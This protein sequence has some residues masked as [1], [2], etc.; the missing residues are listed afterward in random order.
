[1]REYTIRNKSTNPIV[2]LTS[3]V[4]QKAMLARAESVSLALAKLASDYKQLTGKRITLDH[5]QDMALREKAGANAGG[6]W[7]SRYSE[8]PYPLSHIQ[9]T[10]TDGFLNR[11][12]AGSVLEDLALAEAFFGLLD[13][14]L[15]EQ[16]PKEE[17]AAAVPT[18]G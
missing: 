17:Q 5:E 16:A 12:N 8:L 10:F 6:W 7:K 3:A 1:M 15:V 4:M 2:T 9:P 18:S 14:R 11:T 13:L